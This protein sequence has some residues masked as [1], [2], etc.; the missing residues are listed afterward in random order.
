MSLTFL[1]EELG[2]LLVIV[3][4][5]KE[6]QI[7][8]VDVGGDEADSELLKRQKSDFV[9]K[10]INKAARLVW[11][12]PVQLE[13]APVVA[14]SQGIANLECMLNRPLLLLL[15]SQSLHHA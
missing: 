3:K 6:R 15:H 2:E 8:D 10:N 4:S 7:R 5:K 13:E 1:G 14:L 11:R 9:D 12:H